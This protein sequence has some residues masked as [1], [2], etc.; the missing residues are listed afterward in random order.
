MTIICHNCGKSFELDGKSSISRKE[1]CPHCSADIHCCLMCRF[2]SQ[3]SYNEC[4]EPVAERI[5][6][7][8]KANFCDYFS[9]SSGDGIQ[10]TKNSRNQQLEAAAALFKKK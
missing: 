7:K 9:I 6:E 2:Y 5:T 4:T 1:E 8:E 10:S 3:S